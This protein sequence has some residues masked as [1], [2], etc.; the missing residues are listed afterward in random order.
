M[1]GARFTDVGLSLTFKTVMVKVAVTDREGLP[2]S[3]DCTCMVKVLTG[4]S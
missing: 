3:F 4:A 1:F 2:V